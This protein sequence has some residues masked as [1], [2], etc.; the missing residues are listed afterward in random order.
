VT[1]SV[2]YQSLNAQLAAPVNIFSA[3]HGIR[4]DIQHSSVRVLHDP[5][6]QTANV[7]HEVQGSCTAS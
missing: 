1:R 4:S 3:F 7:A 6:P 5:L 2:R